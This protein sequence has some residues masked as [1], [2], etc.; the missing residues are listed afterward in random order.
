[1]QLPPLRANGSSKEIRDA[2]STISTDEFSDDYNT[3]PS[4]ILNTLYTAT[5]HAA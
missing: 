5:G 1:M 2:Q 4:P 3:G